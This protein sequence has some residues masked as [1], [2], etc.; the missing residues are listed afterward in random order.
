MLSVIHAPIFD[1]YANLSRVFKK[2]EN[3]SGVRIT[4]SEGITSASMEDAPGQKV[5]Q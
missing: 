1:Y 5:A 2:E 4:Y 3:I